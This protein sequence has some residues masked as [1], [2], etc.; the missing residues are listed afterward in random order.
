MRLLITSIFFLLIA[1]VV[2]AGVGAEATQKLQERVKPSLVAV[3]YM[4]ELELDRRELAGAGI[5]VR[6]DGLVVCPLGLFDARIPDEQLKDFKIIVPDPA[7]TPGAR[8]ST[9]LYAG[10]AAHTGNDGRDGFL[11]EAEAQCDLG[12]ISWTVG[13][14]QILF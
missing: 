14:R 10:K 5:V 4:W 8:A 2:D 7:T 6:D 3:Q 12:K 9:T 13:G 11:R 1:S